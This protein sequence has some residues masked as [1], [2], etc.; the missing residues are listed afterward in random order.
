M[1]WNIRCGAG[2]FFLK[3]SLYNVDDV[4]RICD[5]I[6][7]GW[8]SYGLKLFVGLLRLVVGRPPF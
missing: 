5:D 4:G 2:V 7:V 8:V 6:V 1:G 3:V